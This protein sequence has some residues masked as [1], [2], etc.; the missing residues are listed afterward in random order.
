M[1]T[2]AAAPQPAALIGAGA[3]A[4]PAPQ[5]EDGAAVAAAGT[6]PDRLAVGTAVYSKETEKQKCNRPAVITAQLPH[7]YYEIQW[8]DGSSTKKGKDS[9]PLSIVPAGWIVVPFATR[10]E[11]RG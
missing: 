10:A 11:R 6:T 8:Q 7:N 5:I 3:V 4:I 2:P 9:S 1:E